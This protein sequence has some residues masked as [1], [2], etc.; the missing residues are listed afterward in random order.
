MADVEGLLIELV[1]SVNRIEAQIQ[2]FES[3]VNLLRN[4]NIDS[5][6]LIHARID[7]YSMMATETSD[8]LTEFQRTCK[9]LTHDALEKRVTKIEQDF[10]AL[11]KDELLAKVQLLVDRTDA[12]YRGY[13]IL[14]FSVKGIPLWLLIIAMTV[15]SFVSVMV[16]HTDWYMR[17]VRWFTG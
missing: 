16:N 11:E 4:D 1:G 3:S 17:Y 13:Q 9:S 8:R 2:A 14:G 5:H 15:I 6:K 12:I 10:S 7:K